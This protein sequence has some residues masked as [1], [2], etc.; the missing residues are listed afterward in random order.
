M[1]FNSYFF[2]ILFIQ[3]S[4]SIKVLIGFT[5]GNWEYLVW[6]YKNSIY[7]GNLNTE[8]ILIEFN[9]TINTPPYFEGG[10]K[11]TSNQ[12]ICLFFCL[13]VCLSVCL[14]IYIL[15]YP[16]IYLSIYLSIHLFIYLYFCLMYVYLS[17]CLSIY[18]SIC[19]SSISFCPSKCPSDC[20]FV[21]LSGYLCLFQ[22]LSALFVSKIPTIFLYIGQ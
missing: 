7:S 20:L 11:F 17:V 1:Y 2:W 14:S 13:S 18:M 9:F 6:S 15:I 19:M 16:S 22:C 5:C 4:P 21:C 3:N 10:C 8:T 12:Y